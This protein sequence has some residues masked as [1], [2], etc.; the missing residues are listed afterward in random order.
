MSSVAMP[1]AT[2]W[3]KCP[4]NDLK[5]YQATPRGSARERWKR[6]RVAVGAA[7][8]R[9][10]ASLSLT[11]AHTKATWFWFGS[12]LYSR[13]GTTLDLAPRAGL[14]PLKKTALALRA[15]PLGHREARH[16]RV[17]RGGSGLAGV[18]SLE[19]LADAGQQ[20]T[21]APPLRHSIGAAA[22]QELGEPPPP[23]SS[24]PHP[25]AMSP[26]TVNT[27]DENAPRTRRNPMG[28][29]MNTSCEIHKMPT[30]DPADPSARF[31]FT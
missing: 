12:Q 5:P 8:G 31:P 23:P 20:P 17:D 21:S 26:V 14:A 28:F 10:G 16:K 13:W 2:K 30:R 18:P 1:D 15:L 11:A 24:E 19:H 22:E 9:M 3:R 4:Q 6:Q 27:S 7:S 25:A 29:M